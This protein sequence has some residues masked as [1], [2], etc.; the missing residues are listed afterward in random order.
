MSS[1]SRWILSHKLAV[2]LAWVVLTI[3]GAAAVGLA[4]HALTDDSSL[5]TGRGGRRT[6]RSPGSTA[7]TRVAARRCSQW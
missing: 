4:S 2:L 7:P 6:R 3:G 5:P 1:F